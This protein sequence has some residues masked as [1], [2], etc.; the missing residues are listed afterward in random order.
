MSQS[1]VIAIT[2]GIGTGKSLVTRYLRSKGYGVVDFDEISRGI[3]LK[4]KD[5]HREIV[6]EFGKEVLSSSGEV[7][8]KK[9]ADIVFS[10]TSKLE[11]L[12][13]ITH[14][15]IFKEARHMME[16][17]KGKVVFLDIPL[18]YEV[19]DKVVEAGID[20]D[21]IWLVYSEREAQIERV[22]SRDKVSYGEA[23]R[24]IDSQVP[25]EKKLEFADKIICNTD[26]VSQVYE[27][28]DRLLDSGC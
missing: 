1:K 15:Y 13:D 20:I 14:K 25:T 12:N 17:A 27:Q 5:A 21:E 26:K 8:R 24:R 16:G 9:L 11:S 19:R 7:D 28:V 18:L 4:G 2:G 10:D 22:M 23:I 6:S 3:Y